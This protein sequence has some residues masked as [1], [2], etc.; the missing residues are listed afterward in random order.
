MLELEGTEHVRAQPLIHI[1]S[2]VSV[3]GVISDTFLLRHSSCPFRRSLLTHIASDHDTSE[4]GRYSFRNSRDKDGI[5]RLY[6][7]SVVIAD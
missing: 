4:Q 1:A 3:T 5:Q 7:R 6:V 2:S